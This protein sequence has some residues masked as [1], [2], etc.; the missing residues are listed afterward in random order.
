[1]EIIKILIWIILILGAGLMIFRVTAYLFNKAALSNEERRY[2]SIV[3]VLLALKKKKKISEKT[4]EKFA[5]N[6]ELRTLLWELLIKYNRI[7][8]FP[9]AFATK[10]KLGESY[11]ANWLIEHESYDHLPN[12]VEFIQTVQIDPAIEIQVFKFKSFEPHEYA[13]KGWLI[14]Y[15]GFDQNW[16]SETNP[17]FIFSSFEANVLSVDEMKNLSAAT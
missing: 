4:L 9:A 6:I 7:E 15:V 2:S 8:L 10:D 17:K 14:G 3:V 12:K 16:R 1:M 13:G 11:L 5:K